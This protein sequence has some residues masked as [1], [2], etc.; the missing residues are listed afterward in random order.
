MTI[1][2][3]T[4]VDRQGREQLDRW[5]RARAP[6]LFSRHSTFRVPSPGVGLPA[7]LSETV[8]RA[9]SSLVEA[10]PLMQLNEEQKAT[11]LGGME[12]ELQ[13]LL[14]EDG[15]I[16]RE[17]RSVLGH[18]GVK[19]L[20]IFANL[21]TTEAKFE[22]VLERDLGLKEDEGM[23]T[24]IQSAALMHAWKSAR[25]RLLSRE[26][27]A[28]EARAQGRPRELQVPEV[29]S[30]RRAH[31]EIYEELDD[32]EFPCR[33][34][35]AWRI[36]EFEDGDY[37][38]EQLT[39]VASV[40]SAKDDS[41]EPTIT[42]QFTTTGKVTGIKSRAKVP[43]PTT[44][45]ELRAVYGLMNVQWEVMKLK[46]PDRA[47]MI[48]YAS[49]TFD[50]LGAYLLGPRVW[51][52]VTPLNIGIHWADLLKYEFEIRKVAMKEVTE[53]GRDLTTAVLSAMRDPG[54][55]SRHFTMAMAT[56]PNR[57]PGVSKPS[58]SKK[59]A[60]GTGGEAHL[61]RQLEQELAKVKR[62][63]MDLESSSG[64][65]H[66]AQYKGSGG[67][68]KNKKQ[69]GKDA[70]DADRAR[71]NDCRRKE[72]LV[73]KL[74]GGKGQ[75]ICNWFQTASCAKGGACTFAHVCMRCHAPGHGILE[76]TAT[77]KWK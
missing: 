38:P 19:K 14:E 35:L 12:T 22:T 28:S 69:G 72:R 1:Q 67:K 32:T 39:E 65:G 23:A 66:P 9:A 34:Y 26:T 4:N 36:A 53:K 3:T 57:N 75:P 24:R 37:K 51:G 47:F 20:T 29:R 45:E 16:N 42:L 52:H 46:Y 49:N 58:P 68:G 44:P 43:P 2:T 8:S 10:M 70:N 17:V 18:L 64:S 60:S 30:V 40:D 25:E 33:D 59:E 15:V 54:L 11:A 63:R 77:P 61:K 71:F 74:D 7:C 62:L 31:K 76:C 55:E 13:A 21:A 48:P 6:R 56:N 27:A 50:R 41:G 5:A 73:I